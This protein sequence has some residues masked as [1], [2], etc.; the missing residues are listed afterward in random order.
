M[1]INIVMGI[2]FSIMGFTSFILGFDNHD[3]ILMSNGNFCLMI[4]FVNL[5]LYK[6]KD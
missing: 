4:G 3:A 6:I 2:I 5:L 1:N